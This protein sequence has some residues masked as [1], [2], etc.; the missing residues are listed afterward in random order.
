MI[1]IA[2]Q[3]F[4]TIQYI[5]CSIISMIYLKVYL[6]DLITDNMRILI[7]NWFEKFLQAK[8]TLKCDDLNLYIKLLFIIILRGKN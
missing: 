4:R 2:L 3:T 6:C 1:S 8:I 7:L 5:F